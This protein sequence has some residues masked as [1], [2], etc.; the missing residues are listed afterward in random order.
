MGVHERSLALI[1]VHSSIRFRLR[2]GRDFVDHTR[3]DKYARSSFWFEQRFASPSQTM[4]VDEPFGSDTEP[5]G[6]DTESLSPSPTEPTEPGRDPPSPEVADRLRKALV[7]HSR[8]KNKVPKGPEQSPPKYG[9]AY[10]RRTRKEKKRRPEQPTRTQERNQRKMKKLVRDLGK[11]A[12]GGNGWSA[13]T[14]DDD[15]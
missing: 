2:F 14:R 15:M 1:R 3:C 5:A 12:A 13:V 4:M 6:S 8:Q 11:V 10:K 9:S 7:R